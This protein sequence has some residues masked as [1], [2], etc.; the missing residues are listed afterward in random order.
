[1]KTKPPATKRVVLRTLA[2]W[3]RSLGLSGALFVLLLAMSGVLINHSSGL[4]LEK[5][6]IESAWLLDLYGIEPP[7]VNEAFHLDDRWISRIDKQIYV[8]DRQAAYTDEPLIGA[9]RQDQMLVVA[10]S[11]RLLLLDLEGNL[12]DSLGREHGVPEALSRLGSSGG[13][14]TVQAHGVRY[15]VDLNNLRWT[16]A[17]KQSVHWSEPEALPVAMRTQ[18]GT[19]ARRHM[20]SLDQVVRDLHSGRILGSWGAWMMDA[21]ALVFLALTVTGIWMWR[22]AKQEFGGKQG[23]RPK[24]ENN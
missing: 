6:Y 9:L 24:T 22:R 14:L 8:N 11:Q 19:L 4:R 1:M 10:T 21:I 7:A 13:R 20:L 5:R 17:S 3:H 12:L 16:K 15:S 2:R 18:I 23:K